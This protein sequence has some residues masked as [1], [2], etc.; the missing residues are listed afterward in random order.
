MTLIQDGERVRSVIQV[1]G[2]FRSGVRGLEKYR[3]CCR[4]YK[5]KSQRVMERD[6]S[7]HRKAFHHCL[8]GKRSLCI[9][10]WLVPIGIPIRFPN[11]GICRWQLDNFLL[12]RFFLCWYTPVHM[13]HDIDSPQR[14]RRIAFAIPGSS[15]PHASTTGY[16]VRRLCQ[17]SHG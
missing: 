16:G 12:R 2:G 1:E 13:L 5:G 11:F 9:A 15:R 10:D 4:H 3:V 6:R 17:L 14:A 7:Q 8:Q